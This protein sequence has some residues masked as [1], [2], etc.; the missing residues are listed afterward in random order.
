MQLIIDYAVPPDGVR[1][2]ARYTL[3]FSLVTKQMVHYPQLNK[4]LWQ[5]KELQK[6]T[7]RF[8]KDS[9]SCEPTWFELVVIQNDQVER[10][11]NLSILQGGTNGKQVGIPLSLM[12]QLLLLGQC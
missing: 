6:D 11:N 2:I 9:N 5:T 1:D 8:R 4:I 7:Y 10:V 12:D 3:P